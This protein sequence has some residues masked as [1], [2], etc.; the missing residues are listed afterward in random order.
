[1]G[2]W[3][4]VGVDFVLIFVLLV[5]YIHQ[6]LKYVMHVYTHDIQRHIPHFLA[7]VILDLQ[8]G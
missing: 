1:V 4:V 6:S 3:W 2:L 7:Q 8:A 5:V